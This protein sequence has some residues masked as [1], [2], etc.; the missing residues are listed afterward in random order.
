MAVLLS[1]W[2]LMQGAAAQAEELWPEL[3]CPITAI[4]PLNDGRYTLQLGCGELDGMA[5]ESRTGP[6]IRQYL[7]GQNKGAQAVSGELQLQTVGYFSSQAHFT[8]APK[9]APPIPGDMVPL[10]IRLPLPSDQLL[11][12]LSRHGI[13]LT[14]QDGTPWVLYRDYLRL[15][16]YDFEAERLPD[17]LAEVH[18]IATQADAVFGAEPLR[19]GLF[20]GQTL[21]QAMAGSQL[22]DL[23]DFLAFVRAFPGKYLG[24]RWKFPEVYATWIINGAPG[25]DDEKIEVIPEDV[26]PKPPED[27]IGQRQQDLRLNPFS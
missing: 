12:H 2:L 23:K 10:E 9:Q 25:P 27:L 6:L 20:A 4:Q 16:G 3:L 14:A 22:N 1:G 17:M 13:V 18:Q 26:Q 15:P 8:L 5:S 21:Q 24:Q 11:F 7:P 19:E